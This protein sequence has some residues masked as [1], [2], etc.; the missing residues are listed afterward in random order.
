M[1]N[2]IDQF[3]KQ[4]KVARENN[5]ISTEDLV[6]QA[7]KSLKLDQKSKEYFLENASQSIED[8]RK[9][10]WNKFLVAEQ[11]FTSKM[12]LSLVDREKV[13][14]MNGEEAIS[15]YVMKYPY[16]IYA[17]SLSNTQSRRSRAGKEF[18]LIIENVLKL[19]GIAVESQGEISKGFYEKNNLSKLVDLIVPNAAQFQKDKRK[20]LF[21]ILQYKIGSIFRKLQFKNGPLRIC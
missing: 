13:K 12:L 10:C 4:V 16:E 14:K 17:L 21:C 11:D 5:V 6:N 8:L 2:K 3:K 1:P 18:E 19:A 15:Y 9:E 20:C 7:I